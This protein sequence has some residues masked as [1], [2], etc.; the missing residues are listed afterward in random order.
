MPWKC[1]FPEFLDRRAFEIMCEVGC[2][3]PGGLH[4][5]KEVDTEYE[6]AVYV[7]D[8][9]VKEQETEYREK[10]LHAELGTH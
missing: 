9:I 3:G 4:G 7:E 10:L 6:C 8:S 5:A 1:G 2:N